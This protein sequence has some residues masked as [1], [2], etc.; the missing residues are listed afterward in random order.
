M[1]MKHLLTLTLIAVLGFAV[2]GCNKSKKVN[3]A[4]VAATQCGSAS[5]CQPADCP[6]ASAKAK[7]AAAGAKSACCSSKAKPAAA[8]TKTSCSSSKAKPA[9]AGTKSGCDKMKNCDKMGSTGC[10][11]FGGK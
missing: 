3:A 4:T 11:M 10:P 8:G 2:V 6:M 7:P 5:D 9:A 1:T